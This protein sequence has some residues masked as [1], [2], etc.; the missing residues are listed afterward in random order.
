MSNDPIVEEIRKI[1][2]DYAAQ[3]NYDLTAL[4][5]DLKRQEQKNPKPHRRL[6]P[7]RIAKSI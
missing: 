2:E 7:R 4:F 5:E 6:Q 3:F 1:R